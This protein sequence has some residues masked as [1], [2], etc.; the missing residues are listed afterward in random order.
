[1][2]KILYK[3]KKNRKL[4]K[5][6]ENIR[7]IFKSII[8]NTK[9]PNV[10]RWNAILKL[11]NFNHN[12]SQTY[13]VRHC[14]LTGRKSKYSKLFKVSRLIFFKLAREGKISGIKKSTW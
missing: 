6:Y 8:K 5:N 3:D 7:F 12:N 2:K 1:M 10:L 11:A 14:L 4:V 9:L 13:L